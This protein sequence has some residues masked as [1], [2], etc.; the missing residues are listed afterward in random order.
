MNPV[1]VCFP[2]TRPCAPEVAALMVDSVRRHMPGA[3]IVQLTDEWTEAV[4]GVDTLIRMVKGADFINWRLRHMVEIGDTFEKI[5]WMD[6]DVIAQSDLREVFD[7]HAFDIALTKRDATDSTISAEILRVCP[8]NM[9]VGWSWGSAW[10]F[11]RKA[12][13]IYQARPRR[14][15][16][17]DGQIAIEQAI[18]EVRSVNSLKVI[19]LAASVYNYTPRSENEDLSG[20]KAVHYKGGRKIW[21]GGEKALAATRDVARR[22][23][24][25]G[26]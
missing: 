10:G 16:W 23:H 13:S 8:H 12:L 20:R 24:R 22:F 18:D 1:H 19:S 9:G 14:D 6:Y 4:P 21:I 3:I 15:G 11:W 2:F 25:M 5:L 26:A 17:M 7:L